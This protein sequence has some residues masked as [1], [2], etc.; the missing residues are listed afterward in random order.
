[1]LAQLNDADLMLWRETERE[2]MA[3]LD[4]D[5]VSVLHNRIRRAL[6][7]IGTVSDSYDTQSMMVPVDAGFLV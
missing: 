3:P 7:S 1:L 4:E 5:G 6:A 2:A